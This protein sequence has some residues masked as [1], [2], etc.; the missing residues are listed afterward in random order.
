MANNCTMCGKKIGGFGSKEFF[1]DTELELCVTCQNNVDIM[2]QRLENAKSLEDLES[3]YNKTVDDINNK[4]SISDENKDVFIGKFANI[5]NSKKSVYTEF[6]TL[7]KIMKSENERK[8]LLKDKESD[9][10]TIIEERKNNSD[11]ENILKINDQYEYEVVTVA[12]NPTGGTN[13]NHLQGVLTKY[14][15]Y[16]WRLKTIVTNELGKNSSGVG[17]GGV[18]AGVNSTID[19][20]I[21]VFERKISNAKFNT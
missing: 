8:K 7:D 21:L 18:S 6:E 12:D 11:I 13:L 2:K 9:I 15:M 5:Y 16:G 3:R 10:D 1:F 14:S 19:Q 4:Y 17:V 20:L